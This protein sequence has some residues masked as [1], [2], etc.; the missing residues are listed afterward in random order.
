MY[1]DDA[2]A[3]LFKQRAQYKKNVCTHDAIICTNIKR[4][5]EK[6]KIAAFAQ[7]AFGKYLC[8]AVKDMPFFKLCT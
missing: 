4:K 3:F 5:N 7:N 1:Y 2:I 6:K 8:M